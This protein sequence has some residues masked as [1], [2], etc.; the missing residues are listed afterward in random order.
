MHDKVKKTPAATFPQNLLQ[1]HYGLSPLVPL[2]PSYP[3][4]AGPSPLVPPESSHS[5]QAGSSPLVPLEPVTNPSNPRI[6]CSTSD[7][8]SRAAHNGYHGAEK[9]VQRYGHGYT[10][11]KKLVL[12]ARRTN[13]QLL[14]RVFLVADGHGSTSF[15]SQFVVD[16]IRPLIED[17][18]SG[19]NPDIQ[20]VILDTFATLHQMVDAAATPAARA[21]GGTTL[22][23]C[24]VD[25]RQQQPIAFFANLGDSPGAVF[26]NDGSG[27]F[28][29]IFKTTDHCATFPEEQARIRAVVPY[30]RVVGNYLDFGPQHPSIQP[31]SGYGDYRYPDGVIR[32]VPEVYEPIPLGPGDVVAVYS[33]G[34]EETV[35]G[36]GLGPGRDLDELAQDLSAAVAN[37]EDIGYSM[38]ERHIERLLTKYCEHHRIVL[39]PQNYQRYYNHVENSMDNHAG[40]FFTV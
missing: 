31:T 13:G 3:A 32:R 21:R 29:I 7:G 38:T 34:Y 17:A 10:E 12:E 27:R 36:D 23:I 11:D 14:F 9:Y 26:R 5:A 33:D 19:P 28:G 35:I 40:I 20:Q 39:T 22:T 6:E 25:H 18:L 4:Q 37:S 1:A 30:A 2:E 16:N 15:F 24:I 8:I